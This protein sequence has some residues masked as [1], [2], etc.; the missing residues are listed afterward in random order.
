MANTELK[1]QKNNAD[2]QAFVAAIPDD[3][4]RA[5]CKVIDAMMEK[6]SGEPG[7]MWGTSIV[8]YGSY[9]YKSKSGQEADWMRIGFSPRKGKTSLYLICGFENVQDL[10]DKLGPHDIGKGCLY[11]KD[12]SKVDQKVLEALIRK[13]FTER[14]V[15]EV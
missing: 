6:A 1:T 8:G 7:V 11:I 4:Q 9:H 13:A 5:D 3:A 14:I 15:N 10:L 12:L 2:V